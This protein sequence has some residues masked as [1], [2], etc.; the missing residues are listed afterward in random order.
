MIRIR[1]QSM[2]LFSEHYRCSSQI[3][4]YFS[5]KYNKIWISSGHTDLTLA[6]K[7]F[8]IPKKNPQQKQ[9]LCL[10]TFFK[11]QQWLVAM[12]ANAIVH[13]KNLSVSPK[14]PLW[15]AAVGFSALL[16]SM[17]HCCVSFPPRYFPF[18]AN[19]TVLPGGP[20][21][22]KASEESNLRP[23]DLSC[24]I[25]SDWCILWLITRLTI[26]LW[27]FVTVQNNYNYYYYDVI[28]A[29]VVS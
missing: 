28:T 13:L 1:T 3:L 27:P 26:S 5:K 29:N 19:Q 6:K 20:T 18:W 2:F 16:V 24:L 10:K 4:H 7:N 22:T 11:H 17:F 21:R 8:F 12:L 9:T 25:V 15:E 14:H 23:C